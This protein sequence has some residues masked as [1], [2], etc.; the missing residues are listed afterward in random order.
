MGTEEGRRLPAVFPAGVWA[1][2][3]EGRYRAS[4]RARTV[5]EQARRT[6]ERDGVPESALQ[7]C[8]PEGPGGTRLDGCLKVYLPLGPSDPRDRPFGMVF[9]DV[10][11]VA[12]ALVL[13]A[14][15]VRHQPQGAHAENV[16]QR[17]HQ[18]LHHRRG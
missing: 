13:I 16:Y 8:E 12:P 5:A 17:A 7:A 4:S 9:I 2:D 18:R 10:G 6:F 3:V 14:Y 15:G 1:A 11:R